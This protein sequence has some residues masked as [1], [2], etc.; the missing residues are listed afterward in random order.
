MPLKETL[1][2]IQ[3]QGHLDTDAE[4]TA[5]VLVTAEYEVHDPSHLDVELAFLGNAIQQR[6]AAKQLDNLKYDYILVRPVEH[7]FLPLEVF[8]LRGL[9]LSRDKASTHP[10]HLQYGIL[11]TPSKGPCEY[12]VSIQ[13]DRKSVV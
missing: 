10:E 8:G 1:K 6:Y 12:Y 9:T 2:R 7:P 5:P 11:D 4:K 3:F 13:L